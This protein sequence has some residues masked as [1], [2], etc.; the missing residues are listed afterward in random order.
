MKRPAAA[1]KTGVKKNRS[2]ICRQR[3]RA[4]RAA[5]AKRTHNFA[6]PGHQILRMEMIFWKLMIHRQCCSLLRR[7]PDLRQSPPYG[8][9]KFL[10]LTISQWIS[11]YDF[12]EPICSNS[13]WHQRRVQ[14]IKD[15]A[16]KGCAAAPQVPSEVVALTVALF[17]FFTG[18]D[19]M[20]GLLEEKAADWNLL[21]PGSTAS[22]ATIFKEALQTDKQP[23]HRRYSPQK[24]HANMWQLASR[25]EAALLERVETESE[26]E[27][28]AVVKAGVRPGPV[29]QAL[30]QACLAHLAKQNLPSIKTTFAVASALKAAAKKKSEKLLWGALCKLP[31]MKGSGYALKNMALLLRDVQQ[32]QCKILGNT[33]SS[34]GPGPRQ[35]YNLQS[36]CL[37]KRSMPEQTLHQFL[38]RDRAIG[39][40][41]WSQRFFG[42]IFWSRMEPHER[43]MIALYIGGFRCAMDKAVWRAYLKVGP[44]SGSTW[45]EHC[46]SC[47]AQEDLSS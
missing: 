14:C 17:I 16:A 2:V 4:L 19:S 41:Y 10:G 15:V 3:K 33:L 47:R 11:D 20:L 29:S 44:P 46:R 24:I 31:G 21:V 45:R 27:I 23:F 28:V 26:D 13:F 6:L 35:A 40:H 32:T 42:E 25:P 8:D 34:G 43:Q 37:R 9:E 1:M 7:H 5:Q 18:S 39:G 38:A 12:E 36:G 30:Q 22:I